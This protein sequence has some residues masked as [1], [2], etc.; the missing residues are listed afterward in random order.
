MSIRVTLDIT[1][2]LRGFRRYVELQYIGTEIGLADLAE[3]AQ[4]DMQETNAHGDITGATRDSYRA[5]VIGGDHTGASEAASGYSAAQAAIAAHAAK[6]FLGH[7]GQALIQDSGVTLTSQQ[8]G[9]MY[10]SYTDYQIKLETENS[11]QKAVIGPEVQQTAQLA[12]KLVADGI[13]EVL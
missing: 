13:R 9:V 3:T 8:R 5:F 11:A 12:A 4:Q 2:I 7:G 6:G 10:T 1:N